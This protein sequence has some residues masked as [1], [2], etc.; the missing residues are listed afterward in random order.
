MSQRILQVNQPLF[1]SEL[2]W[3]VSEKVTRILNTMLD[4]EADELT[5]APSTNVPMAGR[6]IVRAIMSVT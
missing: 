2:D 3:M 1:E 6:R 4:A 5:G